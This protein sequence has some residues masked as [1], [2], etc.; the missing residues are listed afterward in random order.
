M[1]MDGK[2]LGLTDEEAVEWFKY[3][4]NNGGNIL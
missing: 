2:E 1:N 4:C 3:G